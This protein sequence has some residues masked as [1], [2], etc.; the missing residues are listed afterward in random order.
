MTPPPP[1]FKRKSEALG[2][3]SGEP[4]HRGRLPGFHGG[5]GASPGE[6]STI[7]FTGTGTMGRTAIFRRT[8]RSGTRSRTRTRIPRGV[9]GRRRESGTFTRTGTMESAAILRRTSR[10]GTRSRTRTRIPRGQVL[11]TAPGDPKIEYD[12]VYGYGYDGENCNF[13]PYIAKR[14]TFSYSYTNSQGAGVGNSPRRPEDRVRVRLRERVRWG[15]QPFSAVHREAGHVPVLVHEFPAGVGNS[16]RRP[17]D[18]VRV[19]LR[20]RAR[21]GEQ[22]FSDVHS[23]AVFKFPERH[24]AR[25]P[26]ASAAVAHYP[27]S[28]I[29]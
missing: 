7:T 12:Y 24:A 20:E 18:R 5:V 22:P 28:I 29:P 6:S 13:P 9:R 23:E 25:H 27:L 8:S 2:T 11:G 3:D 4:H 15:E 19:R 14:Y 10:S 1:I 16:P 26:P 17:E 21:W